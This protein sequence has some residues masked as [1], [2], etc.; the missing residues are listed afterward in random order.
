[1]L[2]S[3]EDKACGSKQKWHPIHLSWSGSDV[4]HLILQGLALWNDIG[5]APAKTNAVVSIPVAGLFYT[6]DTL[7]T[8]LN[9][10]SSA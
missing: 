3:V 1:M 9:C 2:T 8:K 6:A 10:L 7:T 4:S 5:L